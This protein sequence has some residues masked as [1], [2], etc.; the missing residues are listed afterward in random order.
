MTMTDETDI[1]TKILLSAKKLFAVQGF[2]GT[3]IRQ[4]CEEAGVNIAMVSYHFGGKDNLFGALF[5]AFIPNAQLSSVD[6]NMPPVIGVKLV[7]REV[8][9]Y[10]LSDPQMISIIQQEISM[11][12][13]RIQKIREHVMP[14]WR[15]LRKWIAEGREHGLF[16]FRSLDTAF[17]SVAGTLL[18]HRHQEY[19][20]VLLE[21][22]T[23]DVEATIEDMT[24]YILHGLQYSGE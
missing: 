17:M 21:E 4:I 5:E 8:T 13:P 3:T 12:S 20:K 10:R 11:N 1:K 23:S 19:W 16:Q 9:L 15:L 22:D 18:F 6:P 24:E 2:D 14:M 7:I